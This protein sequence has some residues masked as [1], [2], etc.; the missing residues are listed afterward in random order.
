MGFDAYGLITAIQTGAAPG[1]D[2]QL[3]GLTCWLSMDA[4]CRVHR[5]MPWAEFR[6]GRIV[7]L[8]EVVPPDP[9]AARAPE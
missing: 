9:A 1:V 3:A 7:L 8:P 4:G 5:Q 6:D 2:Q